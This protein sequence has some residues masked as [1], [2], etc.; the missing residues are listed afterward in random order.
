MRQGIASHNISYFSYVIDN[1]FFEAQAVKL[2]YKRQELRTE[3][4]IPGDAYVMLVVSKLS[5]REIPWDLLKA[6]GMPRT[7]LKSVHLVIVGDGPSKADIQSYCERH[8]LSKV[9]FVGYIQYIHLPQYYAMADV[10]IHA[11]LD[12][13]WGVSVQEAMASSLPVIASSTVGAARELIQQGINGFVYEIGDCDQLS[14]C[15]VKC[16]ATLTRQKV[17]EANKKI[18]AN[19]SYESTLETI[20]QVA[21]SVNTSAKDSRDI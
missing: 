14:E 15:I 12:E 8:G 19:W 2:I 21:E 9:I 17:Q 11:P 16:R 6:M 7:N 13:P 10:F 4:N 3:L 20:V 18:L 1:A 5:Q